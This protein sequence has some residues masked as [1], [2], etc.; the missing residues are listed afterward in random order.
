MQLVKQKGY[1]IPSDVSKEIKK[2]MI[3]ASAYLSELVSNKKLKISHVKIGGTPVY[4]IPEN[5]SKLQELYEHL[6][7]KDRDSYNLLKR[8]KVVWDKQLT[9]LQRISMRN[10]KDFAVQLNVLIKNNTEIFWKWYLL[11]DKE[12]EGYVRK[13]LYGYKIEEAKPAT[14]ATKEEPKETKKIKSGFKQIERDVEI[15]KI[16]AELQKQKK[17]LEELKNK[18]F[19]IEEEANRKLKQIERERELLKQ[20]KLAEFEHIAKERKKIEHEKRI[21]EKMKKETEHKL[22]VEKKEQKI[23]EPTNDPFYDR[24]K[25]YFQ[26][27]GIKVI[28]VESLKKGEY[29][30]V[31][32]VE[33]SVGRIVYYA[34]IKDKKKCNEGD[35]STA[36]VKGQSQNLPILFISTGDLTKKAQ[37]ILETEL[38]NIT[39]LKLD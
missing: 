16:I 17:E 36:I 6:N 3:F 22:Y 39:F 32:E 7:P 12:V 21:L 29:D 10:L 2:D 14:P 31:V 9:P 25:K 37:K 28:T 35:L 11:S 33:S 23:Q 27:K 19:F 26:E 5:S 13:I 8:E 34:K 24:I 15:G 18:K 4:Y 20:Q 30:L 38:R 1:V